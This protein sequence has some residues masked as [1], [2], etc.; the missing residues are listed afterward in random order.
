VFISVRGDDLGDE[1]NL[2]PHLVE[3]SSHIICF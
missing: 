2:V 3:S 1:R